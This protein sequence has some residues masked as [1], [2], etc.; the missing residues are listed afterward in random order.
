MGEWILQQIQM[1]E[2]EEKT[3]QNSVSN[4]GGKPMG[5]E[6]AQGEVGIQ[7]KISSYYKQIASVLFIW[8]LAK[9]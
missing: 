3:K 9:L 1:K 7:L 5:K 6:L 2:R 8:F 4:Q